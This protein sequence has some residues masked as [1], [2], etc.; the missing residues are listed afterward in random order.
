MELKEGEVGKGGNYQMINNKGNGK[1]NENKNEGK[2]RA[3]RGPY[4]LIRSKSEYMT[5]AIRSA[6]CRLQTLNAVYI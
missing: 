4:L 2:G 3:A 5:D 1:M 6:A